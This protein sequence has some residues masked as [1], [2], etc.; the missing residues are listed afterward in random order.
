MDST[1]ALAYLVYAA[2]AYMLTYMLYL[3]VKQ[4]S[5]VEGGFPMAPYDAGRLILR[6]RYV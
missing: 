6:R 1:T 5:Y 4:A 3:L 2:T